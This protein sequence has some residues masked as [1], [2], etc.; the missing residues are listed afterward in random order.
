[1][2]AKEKEEVMR[3]FASGEADMLI[4]TTVVE[5][6]V[7]VPNATVMFIEGAE[8]FGL[9]Q[10]HQLRGRV[11]RGAHQ[12]YCFLHPSGILQGLARER[13]H[14]IEVSQDGFD[15]AE[16]DLR[17]RGAGNMY[18]TDQSGFHSFKLG[19]A[20]DID[21]MGLAKDFAKEMLDESADLSKY[22]LIKE[23]VHTEAQEVHF[24]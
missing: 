5:V 19:T 16:Q 23:K 10:L 21:L 22:P 15:L 12:S 17:L 13:L 18:G 8:R 6:G 11:G 3:A 9:A 20:Q 7:D 24:E 14:A 4:S 2:K 1:M